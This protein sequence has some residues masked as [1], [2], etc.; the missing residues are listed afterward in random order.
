MKHEQLRKDAAKYVFTDNG[1]SN[2][3]VASRCVLT[4]SVSSVCINVLLIS[5][6]AE[7]LINCIDV[8]LTVALAEWLRAWDT[9]TMFEA[10]VV[11][12]IPDRG[13]IVG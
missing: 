11:S 12:L 6:G 13:N 4:L 2:Y 1:T 3:G 8:L 10:T 9:L 7:W 5:P